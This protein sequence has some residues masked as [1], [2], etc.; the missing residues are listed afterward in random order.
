[1][2]RPTLL[3]SLALAAVVLLSA[4]TITVEPGPPPPR[5][6]DATVTAGNNFEVPVGTYA[7]PAGGDFLVRVNVTSTQP[8]LYLELDDN[9]DIE[10]FDASR[11]R[12]ASA[13]SSAFFGRGTTGLTPV[14]LLDPQAITTAITC[15][16]S[17]VI[18]DQGTSSHYYVLITN[19]AGSSTSVGLFAY[20]DIMQDDNEP[21]NDLD[22][23][24]PVLN[25][26][27]GE[28][29][30]IEVLGD[31]DFW[32]VNQNATLEFTSTSPELGITVRVYAFDGA[33]EDGPLNGGV[34]PVFA[35]DTLEVRSDSGRA[36]ASAVSSYSLL[37]ASP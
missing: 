36:G 32:R 8:V 34:F 24:A 23:S 37:P 1:M 27:S 17:C 22:S 12:L 19:T 7:I 10:V 14:S 15:R 11:S 9:L 6:P 4:C 25:V 31:V 21:E 2:K 28:R 33:L 18:L 16:G 35:G 5:Q 3:Y 29:G 13:S 30:A 20:G 26:V